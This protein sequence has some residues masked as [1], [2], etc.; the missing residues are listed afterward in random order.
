ME[1][2][3]T[4]IEVLLLFL[5][6]FVVSCDGKGANRGNDRPEVTLGVAASLRHAMPELVAAFGKHH[7]RPKFQIV[8]GSS[9]SLRN[10]VQ[11]GAPIDAVLFAGDAHVDALIE[12]G[13][14]LPDSR[15][16]VGSNGL[17]LIGPEG[18]RRYTF[19]TLDELPDGERLAVGDP[20]AVPAGR[21]ARDALR[22]LGV[23]KALAP[24]HLVYGGDVGAVFSYVRRGEVAAAIVYPTE[25]RGIDDIEI[26]EEAVGDWVPEPA[27][28]VG[29]VNGAKQV[30]QAQKFLEFVA[31]RRG[32]LILAKHGFRPP[33]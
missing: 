23:W 30:Q 1:R 20:G 8:Y 9:G 13:D 28:V 14:V 24:D 25:T 18:G 32:Q 27:V 2:S 10:R 4:R 3:S 26:F 33:R 31:A 15:A 22:K 7:P 17:V 11:L 6:A 19:R 16:V 5:L 21:Y 12:S 29:V